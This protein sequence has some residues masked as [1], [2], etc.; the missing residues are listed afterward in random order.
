MKITEENLEEGIKIVYPP[1]GSAE[2]MEVGD[3][4]KLY[5]VGQDMHISLRKEM[6]L[7]KSDV[8][9]IKDGEDV[10]LMLQTLMNLEQDDWTINKND[11]SVLSERMKSNVPLDLARLLVA[12]WGGHPANVQVAARVQ[13]IEE[14]VVG[15]VAEFL[16]AH[17]MELGNEST[18]AQCQDKIRNYKI[19]REN[20]LVNTQDP[21][22]KV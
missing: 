4:V 6:L 14:R 7:V 5:F 1:H 13:K 17:L 11:I 18:H 16:Q 20:N 21:I 9:I 15:L 8:E 12:L 10:N 22:N 3:E 19:I 2:V